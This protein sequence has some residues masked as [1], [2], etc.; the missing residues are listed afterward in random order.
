MR[1]IFKKSLVASLL[2]IFTFL[3]VGCDFFGNTTTTPSTTSSQTTSSQTTESTTSTTLTTAT[4]TN[5]FVA[6]SVIENTKLEYNLGTSFDYDSIIVVLVKANSQAIPISSSVYSL[7]GFDSSTPGVKTI[8]VSYSTFTTTFNITVLEPTTDLVIDMLYYKNA[9]GL[10]GETLLLALRTIVNNGYQGHIYYDASYELAY[11]DRDP[12]N[13]SNVILVYTGASVSGT[14][15]SGVTWNKEHVW[16]Q[17]LLGED[18]GGTVNMA[19]DIHNLKPANPVWNSSRG[20]KYYDLTTTSTTFEP[21]DEVKGD[22]ARIL[23]YM[24]TMYSVLELVDQY[25]NV[26]QMG[27][28]SVLLEWNDLDPV[29]DFERARNNE[30]YTYQNNRNPYIDYPEFVDLVWDNLQG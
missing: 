3:L 22:V 11:T 29:D 24:V 14:W 25:P 12:N 2:L 19:S 15:D 26:H 27:L 4:T 23:F 21:R 20:N 17:S 6:I 5:G 10:V 9:E 8:T 7:S 16:P 13:S 18:A 30:I 1:P 28:L